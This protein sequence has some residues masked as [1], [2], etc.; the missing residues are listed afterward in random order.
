MLCPL[1]IFT[2]AAGT[3]TTWVGVRQKTCSCE[4]LEMEP[5]S[6]EREMNLILLPWLSGKKMTDRTTLPSSPTIFFFLIKKKWSFWSH[7]ILAFKFWIICVVDLCNRSLYESVQ[8][9]ICDLPESLCF[10]KDCLSTSSPILPIQ[11]PSFIPWHSLLRSV[12]LKFP[13]KLQCRC[14]FLN[15]S[16]SLSPRNPDLSENWDVK[17]KLFLARGNSFEQF[18]SSCR[19]LMK[20]IELWCSA[21]C[22]QI[23]LCFSENA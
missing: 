19:T 18:F 15:N 2:V 20:Y 17:V 7:A 9:V 4:F 16:M 21:S 13:S 1:W 8:E 22:F 5:F 23:K 3:I 11:N 12:I 14:R 10:Y 6:L